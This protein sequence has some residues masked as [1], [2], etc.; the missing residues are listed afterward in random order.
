VFRQIEQGTNPEIEI[1]RSLSEQARFTN[2]PPTAGTLE[3]ISAK[4][5]E[6]SI[7]ILQGYVP[8][9]GDAWEYTLDALGRYAQEVLRH[10]RVQM[11]PI[12]RKPLV[13]L[14]GEL[15]DLATETIGPYLAST[16]TLGQRTAE[17]HAALA[18]LSGRPEFAPERFTPMYLKSMHQSLRASV[19][20]TLDDLSQHLEELSEEAAADAEAVLAAQDRIL[21]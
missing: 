18:S 3:Y 1:A 15:P 4:G 16:I 2:M 13:T 21:E 9:E 14:D 5:Q 11:P 6:Y 19:L 10:P 17:L 12:P 8:N 20:R 7:G